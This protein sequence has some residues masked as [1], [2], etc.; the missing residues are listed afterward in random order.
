VLLLENFV[1]ILLQHSFNLLLS[2]VMYMTKKILNFSR[3]AYKYKIAINF[4][5]LYM[6]F[7]KTALKFSINLL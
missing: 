1:L 4:E 2:P 6:W 3:I 7:F 5:M